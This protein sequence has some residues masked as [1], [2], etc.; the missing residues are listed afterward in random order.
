LVQD[1]NFVERGQCLSY[2]EGVNLFCWPKNIQSF[3]YFT[4]PFFFEQ[5]KLSHP[6]WHRKHTPRSQT[7][8]VMPIQATYSPSFIWNSSLQHI[9]SWFNNIPFFLCYDWIFKLN[10]GMHDPLIKLREN[11][12]HTFFLNTYY[13]IYAAW[14]Q[15]QL[16]NTKIPTMQINTTEKRNKQRKSKKR[17]IK[18]T[19]IVWRC[20]L[21]ATLILLRFCSNLGF[22]HFQK[23][24]DDSV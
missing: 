14:L 13:H 17:N 8:T 5:T 4:S 15:L 6:N 12:T 19:Y 2:F 22:S 20:G 16:Y 18:D 21:L 24:D 11:I 10:C 3:S 23:N 1:S 9:L 7:N